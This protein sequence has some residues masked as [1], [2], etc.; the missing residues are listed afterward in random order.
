MIQAKLIVGPSAFD[1]LSAEWDAL[2]AT[3]ITDT[4]FQTLAYQKAWFTHLGEG[5]LHTVAVYDDAALIGIGCF[6][7]R[8]GVVVFNASKEETDYL[9]V[10]VSAENAEVVWNAIFDCLCSSCTSFDFY[11]IPA[12]SPSRA[13]VEQLANKRGFS[14]AS[15]VA[16]VCPIIPLAGSF[17]DY[18]AGIDKKQRHEI[19]R[20]IRRATGAEAHVRIVNQDDDLTAEVDAFLELLQKST[21]EKRDWLND[22]RTACFHETARTALDAGTLQLMFIEVE[23]QKA[24]GLFN[25]TYK[26]RTWVYNSG[27]DPDVFGR[28]SLGVTLSSKA[29]EKAIELG[30][31]E[32]DF[33][34]G[35]EQYKYRFGAVDS[36]IFRLTVTM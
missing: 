13:I 7:L 35:D 1:E 23:D 21:P 2:A 18:L 16:E 31:T 3:G 28:L 30:N 5:E 34:R 32:F 11:N 26:G 10:M 29:I 4:P 8:D 27:L 20:K 22:A 25:F 14:F 17:D 6:N 15:E 19:K 33:L 9:D 36:E 24:A 12:K